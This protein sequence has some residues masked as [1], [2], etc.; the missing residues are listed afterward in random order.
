MED[1]KP[2]KSLACLCELVACIN[3]YEYILGQSVEALVT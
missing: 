1:V 2:L 3:I